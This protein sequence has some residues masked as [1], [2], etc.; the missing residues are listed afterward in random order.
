[1]TQTCDVQR[2]RSVSLAVILLTSM[3]LLVAEVKDARSQIRVSTDLVLVPVS[4]RNADDEFVTGLTKDDFTVLEDG[5]IQ[6]V[7]SF[8]SEPRPLS[9]AIVIDD[10]IGNLALKRVASQLHVIA[11]GITAEDEVSV[12]RYSGIVDKLSDFSTDPKEMLKS[13]VVISKIAE[14][15]EEEQHEVITGGPGWLRSI[16]G[17]FPD[18]S[19]GSAKNHV[20]HNAIYEA[21]I[22][23]QSRPR[24]RRRVILIVSDGVTSGKANTHSLKDNTDLLL[25]NE[26]EVF[27]VSTDHASFGSYG[28][29]SSYANATGGDVLNGAT[30]QSIE[31]AFNQITEQPRRQYVLGY[32]STNTSG[33]PGVFRKIEVRTR[34]QNLK[35]TYRNGYTQYTAQ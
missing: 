27:A 2:F 13:F 28:A 19:K 14:T 20:L 5:K 25:K 17:I 21:A 3:V 8:D 24:E 11:A 10:G 26:T 30:D 22:A 31:H 6:E 12:F 9:A 18:G 34:Q 7:S 33:K 16:L 23:L 1:M 32:T 29:L 4:A 15:R 35:L